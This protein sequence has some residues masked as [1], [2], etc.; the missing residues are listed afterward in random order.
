MP[1]Q[2]TP[3]PDPAEAK[4]RAV[5]SRELARL[6][7]A[8]PE[9]DLA[10]AWA[11]KDTRFIGVM[12]YSLSLPGAPKEISRA[13]IMRGQVNPIEGTSDAIS[14]PEEAEFNNLAFEYATRYNRL[15]LQ[16]MNE[17]QRVTKN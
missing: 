1:T 10:T 17:Q 5:V 9:R 14:S 2:A 15:L 7:T 12:G 3:T 11:N 4:R 8:S 16:K 13:A 6:K